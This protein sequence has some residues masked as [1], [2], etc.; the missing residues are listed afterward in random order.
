MMD[1]LMRKTLALAREQVNPIFK[2]PT[3][4][5]PLGDTEGTATPVVVGLEPL[6]QVWESSDP[7]GEFFSWEECDKCEYDNT[8]QSDR[9][10]MYTAD[11]VTKLQA[12]V[13]HYKFQAH[14][15]GMLRVQVA[16]LQSENE[17]LRKD[18]DLKNAAL[19]CAKRRI[20]GLLTM[21]TSV[22]TST[23]L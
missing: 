7:C 11:Q 14:D 3:P 22:R 6:Y 21:L 9:H 18:A 19:V 10:I 1:D 4:Q 20:Q 23:P 5:E 2:E 16:A 8:N 12:D 17:A 13:E 15:A